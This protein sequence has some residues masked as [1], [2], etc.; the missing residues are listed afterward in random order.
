MQQVK[1]H[2]PSAGKSIT[3][4]RYLD[5]NR[6]EWRERVFPYTDHDASS[7]TPCFLDHPRLTKVLFLP[8]AVPVSAVIL[9]YQRP[10]AT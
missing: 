2:K 9:H 10:A 3:A 6:M 8:I 7:V 4:G 1:K 5:I